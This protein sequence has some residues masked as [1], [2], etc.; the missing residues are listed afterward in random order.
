[1]SKTLGNEY[2]NEQAR[3]RELLQ[4]YAAIGIAGAFGKAAVERA[5]R[6][7]D[8]AAM[9]GDPVRMLRAYKAMRECQWW[10]Q[11]ERGMPGTALRKKSPRSTSRRWLLFAEKTGWTTSASWMPARS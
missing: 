1:M 5:L 4:D 10:N 6:E 11:T 2:P 9:S 3:L 8:Q 7:A